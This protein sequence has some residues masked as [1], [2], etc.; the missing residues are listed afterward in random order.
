MYKLEGSPETEIKEMMSLIDDNKMDIFRDIEYGV[1]VKDRIIY[2]RDDITILTPGYLRKRI[3]LIGQVSADF[4]SPIT[5]ELTSYGGDVYGMFG[6]LD[7]INIAPMKIH[8]I[9]IGV[10]MSAASFILTAGTGKRA[11]TENSYIM[12]HDV[13]GWIKGKG[14]D[15][16]SETDQLKKM[17]QKCYSIY[18]KNS[19][20]DLAF[21]K[22]KS[23]TTLYLTAQQSVRHGLV[24]KVLKT[25]KIK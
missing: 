1:N 2:L 23:L 11:I 16:I 22:E 20:Q 13:N 7:V 17:Q 10:V 6:A 3:N 19:K 24:D 14:Q 25:W 9:G 4:K 5:L 18:A 21:W 15:L 8:T 12:I